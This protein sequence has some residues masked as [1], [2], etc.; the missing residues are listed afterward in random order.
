[1]AQKIGVEP[2]Y[3]AIKQ[4]VKEKIQPGMTLE[5]GLDNLRQI[6]DVSTSSQTLSNGEMREYVS[7]TICSYTFT[8]FY[9]LVQYQA[10]TREIL[11]VYEAYDNW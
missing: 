5:E 8:G 3:G 6:T 7:L 4:Y 2:T 11:S 1:V 10:D 9:L